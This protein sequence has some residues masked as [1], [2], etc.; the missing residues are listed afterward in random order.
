MLESM[1]A[2]D[3]TVVPRWTDQWTASE[4]ALL[5]AVDNWHRS[6]NCPEHGD[7]RDPKASLDR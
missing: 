5:K 2:I 4:N 1:N 3:E 6:E 7:Q